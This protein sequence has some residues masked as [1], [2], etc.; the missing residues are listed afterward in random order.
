MG[1]DLGGVS[2]VPE[3]GSNTIENL[4]EV[5]K[6]LGMTGAGRDTAC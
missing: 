6:A 3:F 1:E 5:A 2:D 4:Q